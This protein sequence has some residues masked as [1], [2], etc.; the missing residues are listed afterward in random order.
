MRLGLFTSV[1]HCGTC[2]QYHT[3]AP[4][5]DEHGNRHGLKEENYRVLSLIAQGYTRPEI[6]KELNRDIKHVEHIMR[7]MF[8]RFNALNVANLIAVTMT[9][10]MLDPHA[11]VPRITERKH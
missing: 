6:A 1:V 4:K 2:D 10:G 5:G 9:L 8:L 3:V 11:F 7:I